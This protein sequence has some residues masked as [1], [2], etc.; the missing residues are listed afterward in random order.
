MRSLVWFKGND[1]RI[2]DNPALFHAI[3]KSPSVHAIFILSPVEEL[4]HN[5]APIQMDYLLR[6]LADLSA[7]LWSKYRIPLMIKTADSPSHVIDII[8][9]IANNITHV[10]F[11]NQYEVDESRRD[12]KV[13]TMLETMSVKVSRFDSDVIIK[14]ETLVSKSSGRTYQVYTPF[15]KA[16]VEHVKNHPALLTEVF[17]LVTWMNQAG[18]QE[19]DN[20][21]TELA[22]FELTTELR[23]RMIKLYPVGEDMAE[24]KLKY[25]AAD[26]IA[27]YQRD[28][29][30][31]DMEGTSKLS[32]FLAIGIYTSVNNVGVI[33]PKQCINAAIAANNGNIDS[34]NQGAVVWIQE[35][36]WR[37]FYKNI[38]VAHPR[39]CMGKAYK[40]DTESIPWVTNDAHFEAWCKVGLYSLMQGS[41]GLS[42][43]RCGDEAIEGDWMDA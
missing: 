35:L 17:L 33:S 41:N 28:R 37:E 1:L 39:V 30:F 9:T 7:K 42:D 22:G 16:W 31:P 21:P 13:Q 18:T 2:K 5:R 6:S 19:P 23:E 26:K 36:I 29:D 27:N 10:F 34:G 4:S 32:P 38:L 12:R 3:Q 24:E 40:I 15:R 8:A 25:F 14:P 20:V 43:C 11:N